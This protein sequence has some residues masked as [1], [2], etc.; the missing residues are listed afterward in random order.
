MS[1]EAIVGENPGFNSD[2][3]SLGITAIECAEGQPPLASEYDNLRDLTRHIVIEP[4]PG[5]ECK[6]ITSS[7]LDCSDLVISAHRCTSLIDIRLHLPSSAVL[8]SPK[9]M[10]QELC[11]L[12]YSVLDEG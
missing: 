8:A 12:H 7:S 5:L 11:R 2:V 10:E 3:W 6:F 4:P 1:P 9:A